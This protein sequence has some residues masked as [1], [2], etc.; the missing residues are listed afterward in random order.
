MTMVILTSLIGLGSLLLFGIATGQTTESIII[1]R[2]DRITVSKYESSAA[3]YLLHAI[4]DQQLPSPIS[5]YIGNISDTAL[6]QQITSDMN[7]IEQA[8][9]VPLFELID[10]PG[11]K[12]IEF[13]E[14]GKIFLEYLNDDS[15]N[16]K[17]ALVHLDVGNVN[18]N[19]FMAITSVFL[20]P[21]IVPNAVMGGS[22]ENKLISAQILLSR[23]VEAL[24]FIQRAPAGYQYLNNIKTPNPFIRPEIS[25]AG[26]DSVDVDEEFTVT[27]IGNVK[28]FLWMK[29]YMGVFSRVDKVSVV[30]NGDVSYT[31]SFDGSGLKN[32]GVIGRDVDN[33]STWTSKYITVKP[34]EMMTGKIVETHGLEDVVNARLFGNGAEI[35]SELDGSYSFP[36]NG[37]EQFQLVI[38]KDGYV[39]RTINVHPDSLKD[40]IP[41]DIVNTSDVD[42][43]FYRDVF[44]TGGFSP[45]VGLISYDLSENPPEKWIGPGFTKDNIETLATIFN[46]DAVRMTDG[47][48]KVSNPI[49]L[50]DDAY[51][52]E[53][54]DAGNIEVRGSSE[55]PLGGERGFLRVIPGNEFTNGELRSFNKLQAGTATVE[56]G[57]VNFVGD[58][59]SE[60]LNLYIGGLNRGGS[61][62]SIF[63]ASIDF[64]DPKPNDIN[65]GIWSYRR[66]IGDLN[67]DNAR[68]DM[69]ENGLPYPH[70]VSDVIYNSLT[71]NVVL[72]KMR[73]LVP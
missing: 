19:T 31:L 42:V 5:T 27:G 16:L 6:Q 54:F 48:V 72:V 3:A 39:T 34:V 1:P 66:N 43:D 56:Q 33:N 70:D 71:S 40:D 35:F 13:V 62:L 36:L 23:E 53:T 22:L 20:Y 29:D 65:C 12:G 59:T 73:S 61:I 37:T 50:A 52:S 69:D 21:E 64:E 49:F 44:R 9:G 14:D 57:G 30:G 51:S 28:D 58:S 32:I 38:S 7:S 8:I 41:I 25:V 45:L 47:Y 46:D 26:P 2:N 68:L 55:M 4:R 10:Q 17:K 11:E 24:K 67:P 60:I 18:A 15:G 63:N